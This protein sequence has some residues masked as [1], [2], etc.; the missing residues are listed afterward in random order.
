MIA[1]MNESLDFLRDKY[2]YPEGRIVA[3]GDFFLLQCGNESVELLPHRVERRFTELK[4]MIAGRTLEDVSTLRFAKFTAGGNL[5]RILA[6]QLD[7][8][9]MLAESPVIRIFASGDGKNTCN[10]IVRFA[11]GISASIECGICL[12]EGSAVQDRH[13]IIARR[14]VGC[15]RTVDT[16]VA[17]SSI[18]LWNQAGRKEYTDVDTELFGLPDEAI[19]NIR[20]ACAVLKDPALAAVWKKCAS[21]SLM[22]ADAALKSAAGNVPVMLEGEG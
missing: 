22:L 5:R 1:Q 18:Y 17:Q 6:E 16:Q 21:H 10:A 12:P 3:G 14:G 9:E 15:D 19:W 20:A 2:G 8:A 11:N 13:E 7:L 4:N